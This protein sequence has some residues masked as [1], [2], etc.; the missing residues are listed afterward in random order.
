MRIM[1]V[2]LKKIKIIAKKHKF[3]SKKCCVNLIIVLL[4]VTVFR[5][6]NMFYLKILMNSRISQRIKQ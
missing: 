5:F 4:Y 6:K 2:K 3:F 1:K